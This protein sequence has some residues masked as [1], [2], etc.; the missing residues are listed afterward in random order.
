MLLTFYV[1]YKFRNCG[2]LQVY[3]FNT[4]PKKQWPHHQL[5]WNFLPICKTIVHDPLRQSGEGFSHGVISYWVV[6]SNFW[7][8]QL[9]RRSESISKSGWTD[10]AVVKVIHFWGTVWVAYIMHFVNDTY[11]SP[12][13]TNG[14]SE[15]SKWR[16]AHHSRLPHLGLCWVSSVAHGLKAGNHFTNVFCQVGLFVQIERMWR[17]GENNLKLQLNTWKSRYQNGAGGS[18]L[19]NTYSRRS[20]RKCNMRNMQMVM[21]FKW[22]PQNIIKWHVHHFVKLT[23]FSISARLLIWTFVTLTLGTCRKIW[24]VSCSIIP[25]HDRCTR[26]EYADSLQLYPLVQY[27]LCSSCYG[28]VY[29]RTNECLK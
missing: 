11:S 5:L 25:L 7:T 2:F 3:I 27:D 1:K 9:W 21:L 26:T 4:D 15:W 16:M 13:G 14:C 28:Q 12:C 6:Y 18:V 23:S 20:K 24:N 29:Q 10:S 17:R 22:P 19:I 8:Q